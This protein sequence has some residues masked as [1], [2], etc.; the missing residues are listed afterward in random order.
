MDQYRLPRD[1]VP[2][3]YDLRLEPDLAASTFGGDETIT[4]TVRE[5]TDELVLNAAE[6]EIMAAAIEN[7]AGVSHRGTIELVGALERCRL[8][9][10][11]PLSPGTW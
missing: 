8:R 1:V 11:N 7:Q 4:V 9:F 2:T 3:R 10:P 6:L 5:T